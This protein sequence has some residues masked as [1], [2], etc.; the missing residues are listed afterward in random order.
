[1]RHYIPLFF[2]ICFLSSSCTKTFSPSIDIIQDPYCTPNKSG[3]NR[4]SEVFSIASEALKR[5]YPETKGG[6]DTKNIRNVIPYVNRTRSADADTLFYIVNYGNNDGFCLVSAK[7]SVEPILAITENGYYDGGETGNAGFDI[8]ISGL[9][10]ELSSIGDGGIII[11][12]DIVDTIRFT[13]LTVGPILETTWHQVDPYN[14]YCPT[15]R[16]EYLILHHCKV[17]CGAVALSQI[18][19]YYEHPTSLNLTFSGAPVQTLYPDWD[20]MK[21]YSPNEGYSSRG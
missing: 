13:E 3:N 20:E 10:A 17:G 4:Y 11:Q 16:D 19:A 5:F 1:M 21:E 7:K 15:I 14:Y 6:T 8:Y 12:P 9:V 2:L 18:A